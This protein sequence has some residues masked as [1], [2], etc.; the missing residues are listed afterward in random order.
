MEKALPDQRVEEH[1]T[2]ETSA[3][4]HNSPTNS[5]LFVDCVFQ[6]D[7]NAD[8][9]A[10]LYIESSVLDLLI[11]SEGQPISFSGRRRQRS[12]SLSVIV[13]RINRRNPLDITEERRPL[14]DP[15]GVSVSEEDF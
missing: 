1:V 2:D 5:E 4:F 13:N 6:W 12:R 3:Q 14:P 11:G 8:V 10:P 9:S 7:S 15:I